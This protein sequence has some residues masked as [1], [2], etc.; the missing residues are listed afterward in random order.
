[1]NKLNKYSM[2]VGLVLALVIVA[3]FPSDWSMVAD[4][5]ASTAEVPAVEFEF[6]P[7]GD[8]P[9]PEVCC[10]EEFG[11]WKYTGDDCIVQRSARN[12]VPPDPD[13]PDNCEACW[14][15]LP[16]IEDLA[17]PCQGCEF[18]GGGGDCNWLEGEW[19]C[20]IGGSWKCSQ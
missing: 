4:R 9:T 6:S 13:L 11:L 1:M 3:I 10:T 16:D 15:G 2:M 5:D 12:S 20:I 19:H 7:V 14:E 8:I 17:P 18:L